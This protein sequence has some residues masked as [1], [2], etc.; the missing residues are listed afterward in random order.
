MGLEPVQSHHMMSIIKKYTFTEELEL[1]WFSYISFQFIHHKS[2]TQKK[3]PLPKI[4]DH[5]VG[6][7][8]L[9]K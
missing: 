4:R 1:I 5:D 2:P 7:I 9:L 6:F 8:M 3:K